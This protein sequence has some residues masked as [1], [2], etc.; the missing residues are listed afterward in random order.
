MPQSP[1][2]VLDNSVRGI[3]ACSGAYHDAEQNPLDWTHDVADTSNIG[4]R[5]QVYVQAGT[6]HALL[7]DEPELDLTHAD[8]VDA[9]AADLHKLAHAAEHAARVLRHQTAHSE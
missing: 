1:T 4:G 6:W 7:R 3:T 8:Q 9:L 5:L 2:T